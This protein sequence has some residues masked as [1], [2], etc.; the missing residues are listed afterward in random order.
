MIAEPWGFVCGFGAV[1]GVSWGNVGGVC[2][3]RGFGGGAF[4]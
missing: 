2:L 4:S 1:Y 3:F